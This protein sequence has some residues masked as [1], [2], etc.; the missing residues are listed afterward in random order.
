MDFHSYQIVQ[1]DWNEN[2]TDKRAQK[3]LFAD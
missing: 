1:I 3:K 2:F